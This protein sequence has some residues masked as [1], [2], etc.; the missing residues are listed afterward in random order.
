MLIH[1]T[2]PNNFSYL[3]FN[4][5]ANGSIV[6]PEGADFT[7]KDSLA[8]EHYFNKVLGSSKFVGELASMTTG[9]TANI[10][11]S[12]VRE[13]SAE[14]MQVNDLWF[15]T[16]LE[17]IQEVNQTNLPFFFA[18]SLIVISEVLLH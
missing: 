15:D 7:K 6:R 13:M 11:H 2:G 17:K 12:L 16:N 18:L 10:D 8:F 4:R 1:T 14:N 5:R 3:G 9:A